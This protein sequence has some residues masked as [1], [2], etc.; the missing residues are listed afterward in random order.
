MGGGGGGGGGGASVEMGPKY[1][2]A[3]LGI[4]KPTVQQPSILII[5]RN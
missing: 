4:A 1:Y 2:T 5:L 3:S